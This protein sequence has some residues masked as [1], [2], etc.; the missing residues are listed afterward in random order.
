[1]IR[2]I[3]T[4]LDG[5][6]LG[7]DGQ[8]SRRT[9]AAIAAADAAGIRVIAATGRSHRTAAHRLRP[10]PQLRTMV[11][12]NGALVYDLRRNVVTET[13]PLSGKAVRH[14]VAHLR[15]RVPQ[16]LFGWETDGGFGFEPGFGPPA[17][18]GQADL[19][20]IGGPQELSGVV[21]A[22]KVFI[23]HPEAEQQELQQLIAPHLPASLNGATSG[24]RFVEV[25]AA[26]VD[27]G[28]TVAAVAASLGIWR[29]EVLAM[30]DEMNDAPL[31]AWAGVAVAMENGVAAIKD[32]ADYVAKPSH[33]D[34]AAEMIE[35]VVAGR[36][37]RRDGV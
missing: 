4:D 31:L 7:R 11:C 37:R 23:V 35:A 6:L 21:S 9:V 13:K 18:A 27:K 33:L 14:L 12:S 5:T 2:L 25:T 10:A 28:R 22:L 32:V 19:S 36:A 20:A 3:A 34:G 15:E 8:L 29:H 24:A 26:G 30:G 1:M 16:L 17:G